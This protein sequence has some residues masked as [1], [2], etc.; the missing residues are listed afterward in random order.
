MILLLGG[1]GESAFLASCLVQEGYPVLVSTASSVP[2]DIQNHPLI[3]RR[4]GALNEAELIALIRSQDI[5]AIVD[6]THP[7]AQNISALARKTADSNGLPYFFWNRPPVV[8]RDERCHFAPD[9]EKA[10]VLAFSFQKPVLLT[11]GSRNLEPYVRESLK[12]QVPLWA[13]V[14]DHPDS[15]AACLQAGIP[16]DHILT[17]RGPFSVEENK[18]TIR[19]YAIG[20]LVTKDS[21]L[22]GGVLNKL[23][24]ARQEHCRVVVIERPPGLS[25]NGFQRIGDLLAALERVKGPRIRGFEGSRE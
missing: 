21:G 9:H 25:E 17:G 7:Y 5:R 11:T 8:S 20:V 16:E 23:E 2:L 3:S 4:Q 14:L 19:K 13:R 10:A 15:K 22:P 24:A 6:A 18:R 12:A 1:T